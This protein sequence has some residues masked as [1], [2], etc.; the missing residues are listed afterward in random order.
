MFANLK[1]KIES[2]VGELS[3]LAPS[4]LVNRASTTTSSALSS[5]HA[6]VSSL[7]SEPASFN[8]SNQSAPVQ[9]HSPL[10]DSAPGNSSS[11]N[12][13]A[14]SRFAFL[15][16]SSAGNTGLTSSGSSSSLH[17]MKIKGLEEKLQSQE[18]D[19]AWRLSNKDDEISSLNKTVEILT[20]QLRAQDTEVK[21]K[22]VRVQ[23]D[24]DDLE[25][26][27]QQ[28]NAKLKHLLLNKEEELGRLRSSVVGFENQVDGLNQRV[29]ELGVENNRLGVLVDKLEDR[30]RNRIKSTG[31]ANDE[32]DNDQQQVKMRREL[33][34]TRAAVESVTREL[35]IER[36]GTTSTRVE[37]ETARSE[38][39]QLASQV[40][41]AKE[42]DVIRGVEVEGLTENLRIKEAE[43]T[44]L[45]G[46]NQ[47][48]VKDIR[49]EQAQRVFA[50]QEVRRLEG[51]VDR[52]E[53]ETQ[54]LKLESGGLKSEIQTVKSRVD[55]KVEE[56]RT[57]MGK[58]L[59]SVRAQ[60]SELTG[61]VEK[62]RIEAEE[63]NERA[64]RF[65]EE[66]KIAD[67]RLIEVTEN[68]GAEKH[69]MYEELEK[70]K[71][72]V[73]V[74]EQQISAM[75]EEHGSAN[76]SA[77]IATLNSKIE[78]LESHRVVMSA[79]VEELEAEK[80]SSDREL[81]AA[82]EE[83]RRVNEEKERAET[84]QNRVVEELRMRIGVV[85][86]ENKRVGEELTRNQELVKVKD[87][88]VGTLTR[89]VQDHVGRVKELETEAAAM[90]V[91]QVA[92]IE[93]ANKNVDG[94]ELQVKSLEHERDSLTNELQRERSR[95]GVLEREVEEITRA[96]DLA[97]EEAK[98]SETA[99]K[100]A[101]DAASVLSKTKNAADS[102][103]ATRNAKVE[104]LQEKLRKAEEER[105]SSSKSRNDTIVFENEE[106]RRE[107][108]ALEQ[109]LVEMESE[110]DELLVSVSEIQGRVDELEEEC[111]FLREE[112]AAGPSTGAAQ[113]DPNTLYENQQLQ[114][115]LEAT[116]KR[117][118]ELDLV[119]AERD[120]VCDGIIFFYRVGILVV[121]GTD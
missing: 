28:E 50:E 37:L 68:A 105:G 6:S 54:T 5:R 4:S 16:G 77:L 9:P 86:E 21:K 73:V 69:R 41:R 66:K 79:R 75:Q 93:E 92:R 30:G 61:V 52:L 102:E 17:A 1:K 12:N 81:G 33:D 83:L 90:K 117:V 87:A 120:K 13:P 55:E 31:S 100:N 10:L 29:K 36:E 65:E 47:K 60:V 35:E 101:E 59:E 96:R 8:P 23:E 119:V 48:L 25:G 97:I 88:E 94:K 14:A 26:F 45:I 78:E 109:A 85:E 44:R 99:K 95:V 27:S 110:K 111:R 76:E 106:L 112:Q 62:R 103:L 15:P 89:E 40:E 116:R 32:D 74:A 98:E 115:L 63:A 42:R 70:T 84:S 57:S 58:E 7:V 71:R 39:R 91:V 121:M 67:L 118:A 107:K 38:N 24:I 72:A 113:D 49:E 3:R 46:E 11:S 56:T 80:V 82:T 108:E 43:V 18:S 19:F 20:T 53:T 2:E 104:E 114:Q 51:E 34:K 22:L 64:R